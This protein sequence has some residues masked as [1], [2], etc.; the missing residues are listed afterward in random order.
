MILQPDFN[1]DY[2][3]VKVVLTSIRVCKVVYLRDFQSFL[4]NIIIEG[5]IPL[6]KIPLDLDEDDVEV[7]EVVLGS[8]GDRPSIGEGLV[9]WSSV[10]VFILHCTN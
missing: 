5:Y 1:S 10:L 8:P 6:F 7:Q 9:R 3:L 2:S 4:T